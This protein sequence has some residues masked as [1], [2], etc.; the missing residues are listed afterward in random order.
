MKAAVEESDWE[1]AA[2][3]M[4][5]SNWYK[6]VGDRA[7]DLVARMR[8]VGHDERKWMKAEMRKFWIILLIEPTERARE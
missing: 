8:N 6:Q 2:D 5:D 3:E 4:V 7:K 1:R